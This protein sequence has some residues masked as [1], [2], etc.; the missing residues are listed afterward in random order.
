MR[1]LPIVESQRAS[2]ASS[3]WSRLQGSFF[4]TGLLATLISAGVIA[5]FGWK[6][7][8]LV[9]EAPTVSDKNF[10]FDIMKITPTQSWIAWTEEFRGQV[11]GARNKPFHEVNRE[12]AR[13]Y[14]ELIIAA[15]VF[16]ALGL[17]AM[18]ASFL[19]ST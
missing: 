14:L 8:Q 16:L 3:S 9:T 2:P 19:I 18:I 12:I 5:N 4:A 15:G 13:R 6:R 10:V 11:L 1:H 7:S 17:A